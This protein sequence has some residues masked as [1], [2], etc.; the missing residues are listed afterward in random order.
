MAF[1][2]GVVLPKYYNMQDL[3]P[4]S[5]FGIAFW[6]K[7]HQDC[8]TAEVGA[9]TT[10]LQFA[11]NKKGEY[12]PDDNFGVADIAN[13]NNFKYVQQLRKSYGISKTKIVH[14]D[15][16]VEVKGV[17]LPTFDYSVKKMVTE[18]VMEG[19]W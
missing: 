1:K 11:R 2:T 18:K 12:D 8:Y 16:T 10:R 14:D 5:G 3:D 4:I 15:G 9:S 19:N 6:D 17:R 13:N 7:A